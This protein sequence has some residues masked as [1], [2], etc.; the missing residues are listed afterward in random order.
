MKLTTIAW[1]PFLVALILAS[2]C[3]KSAD[4]EAKESDDESPPVATKK[5]TSEVDKMC[6]EILQTSDKM[7]AADWL[8][9]YPKSAVGEDEEGRQILLAPLIARVRDAGAK[10]IVIEYAKLGQGEVLVS[11]VVVLPSEAQTRQKLFALEPE[12]SQLCQQTPVS[13]KGQKY[14]HYSFD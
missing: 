11:M 3:S 1:Q 9:R 5:M 10:R 13:D 4:K 14:L 2:A 7:E 12:L 6:E 8:N